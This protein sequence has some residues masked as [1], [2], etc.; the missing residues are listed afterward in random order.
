MRRSQADRPVLAVKFL[1]AG[2]GAEQRG[3]LTRNVVSVNR[4]LWS[5]EELGEH[6]KARRQ[7][8]SDS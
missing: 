3:R 7:A 1:L 4:G 6:A 8:V 5:W 2:V